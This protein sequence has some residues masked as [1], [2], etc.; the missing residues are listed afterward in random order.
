M[1][2]LYSQKTEIFFGHVMIKQDENLEKCIISEMVE[3]TRGSG[4][5]RWA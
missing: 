2:F 3:G 4:R 5:P 1:E